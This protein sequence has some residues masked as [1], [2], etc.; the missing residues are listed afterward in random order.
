MHPRDSSCGVC[1]SWCSP[2][3]LL[4]ALPSQNGAGAARW[5]GVLGPVSLMQ[6]GLGGSRARQTGVLTGAGGRG[7]GFTHCWSHKGVSS[8][9]YPAACSSFPSLGA[10]HHS[11]AQPQP[12][13]EPLLGLAGGRAGCI[14]AAEAGDWNGRLCP[15]T[16]VCI[17][18]STT[19]PGSPWLCL[20]GAGV[21]AGGAVPGCSAPS[22]PPSALCS[23]AHAGVLA[24]RRKLSEQ[25]VVPV[26]EAGDG[27]WIQ[28]PVSLLPV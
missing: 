14:A 11:P 28:L 20:H 13:F 25:R 12:C 24:A 22:R 16:L 6:L 3:I 27:G 1:P 10:V 8:F 7:G 9:L 23:S 26:A 18:C 15:R 2:L 19:G 21:W 4:W 5:L 17:P